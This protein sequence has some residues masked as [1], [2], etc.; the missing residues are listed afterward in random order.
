MNI[1]SKLTK[2]NGAHVRQKDFFKKTKK[3][4]DK[5]NR[6]CYNN[7]RRKRDAEMLV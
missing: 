4:L 6:I 2:L 1:I 5:R 3:V 7:D